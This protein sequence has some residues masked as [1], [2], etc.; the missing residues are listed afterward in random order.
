MYVPIYEAGKDVSAGDID[1][2]VA[3]VISDA[4]DVLPLDGDVG[5]VALA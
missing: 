3:A 5:C 4:D 1:F 2:L